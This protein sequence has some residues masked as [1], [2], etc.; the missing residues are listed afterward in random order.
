MPKNKSDDK[1]TTIEAG[2]YVDLL[3]KLLKLPILSA[4]ALALAVF[5][6]MPE[7]TAIQMGIEKLRVIYK[8]YAACA[9][10]LTASLLVVQVAII[11]FKFIHQKYIYNALLKNWK[12]R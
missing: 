10:L 8:S 2:K 3:N 9:L 5:F 1:N 6:F 12:A 7:K 4:I 11:T